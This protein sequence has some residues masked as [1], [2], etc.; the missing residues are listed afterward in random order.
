MAETPDTNEGTPA[1]AEFSSPIVEAIRK[2]IPGSSP[3][4]ADVTYDEDFQKNKAEIDRLGTVSAKIDQ[5]RAAEDARQLRGMTGKQLRELDKTRGQGDEKS[6]VAG[7]GGT[8]TD[9]VVSLAT[10]ILGEKSK[11]LRVASYLCFALWRGNTFAGLQEGMVGIT[12]LIREFWEGM[13]PAKSRMA[14][15]KNAIE[16][17]TSK[18]ADDLERAQ[19]G[20]QDRE[21]LENAKKSIDDLKPLLAE[22]FGENA[23][24]L[25]GVSAGLDACIRKLPK[26]VSA[27]Q[28][29]PAAGGDTSGA[30]GQTTSLPAAGAGVGEI[31]TATDAF[32]AVKKI[33]VFLR[34]QDRKNPQ[35]YRLLRVMR[36]DALAA[37]PPNEQG[38]TKIPPPTAQRLVFLNGLLT[39]SQWDK[40][41]DEG[42]TSFPQPPFHFWLDLQRLVVTA[43]EA[44]GGFEQAAQAILVEVAML[45][46]RVPKLPTMAFNDGSPFA[47]PV[48]Q[49]WIQERALAVL[50][51]GGESET[52]SGVGRDDVMFG[53]QFA[54][55][56]AIVGKGDLAGA[57]AYLQFTA[58]LDAA[59]RSRF[60][61]RHLMA[62]LCLRSN[63]PAIA[64]PILEDLDREIDLVR[65]SA[66][67]PALALAV[68]TD[69]YKCYGALAGDGSPAQR[70]TL[71]DAADQMFQ[72]ICRVD[73]NHALSIMGQKAKTK[74]PA[75]RSGRP[76]GDQEGHGGPDGNAAP[77]AE[78]GDEGETS[79]DNAG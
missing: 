75:G 7:G 73:A 53:Q 1:P 31:K 44:A 4:G 78:A 59:G 48:T 55:A 72:K 19:V 3:C 20:A 33:A 8:D 11:D 64:R 51:G 41:I 21:P 12:V 9:L 14:A 60:R 45:V 62:N 79:G 37:E 76:T 39:S 56:R 46:Q 26:H 74:L 71:R 17:L 38:K 40:L 50:G 5:E 52:Q 69:L 32:D 18:L 6:F 67:E 47:S 29:A 28:S 35:G 15:R 30:S 13:F 68:Y 24:S 65:L 54:E 16:F 63:Q 27:A 25:A 42:E 66:W 58:A 49:D 70:Q 2:P 22:R 10:R 23:P 43:M 36:W 57:L 77:V 61:L 34:G